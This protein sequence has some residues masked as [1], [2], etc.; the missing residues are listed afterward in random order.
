MLDK[1]EI[2]LLSSIA[3]ISEIPSKGAF[4]LRKNG[5]GE[6]RQSSESVT[7][8]PKSDKPGIDIFVKPFSEEDSVHIPV[9]VTESGLTDVVYNDFYIGEG[10]KVRIVAGC[11][12]HNDGEC[13]SRH[14]GIHRFH[15]GK[16]ASV[17]YVEKH[18]GEGAGS[19]ARI[20][21]PVTEVYMEE[22]SVCEMEMVQIEGVN[23][24][25][26]DTVAKL[27]ESARL[28]ITERLMTSGEQLAYS[29]VEIELN[30]DSSSA[31][32]ISR[33][34]AKERSV[35]QFHYNAVGN[36]PC[37]AH[38][39]CDSIIMDDA[40]VS[41][42]PTITANCADAAIIHEAAIGRINND[43]ITK[44]LTLG[45]SET[46]AEEIIIQGFLK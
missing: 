30:G 28:T 14:D 26:R 45:L 22:G 4:N 25:K 43:Q 20:L 24:T 41:S 21:N 35:Q 34:V 23:S 29:D 17:T 38:I 18:Y 39:Q 3:D 15:I 44:L 1:Y 33:S 46:E 32:L 5:V 40:H 8:S 12:I 2:G 42:T 11:G 19:G 7:I 10:A 31:Q 27:A 13:D 6:V 16:N 37:R 36:A 9:I